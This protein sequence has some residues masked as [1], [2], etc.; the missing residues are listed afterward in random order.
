MPHVTRPTLDGYHEHEH[1]V[2]RIAFD[3]PIGVGL[4]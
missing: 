4:G 1:T 3:S 2:V